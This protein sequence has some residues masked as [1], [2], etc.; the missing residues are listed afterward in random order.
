MNQ[1]GTLFVIA[2]TDSKRLPSKA[3]LKIKGKPLL[4]ILVD[5]IRTAKK[6]SKIV[7]CT[8]KKR[9]DNILVKF[10]KENNIDVYRGDD[11]DILKRI[12]FAAKKFQ[13]SNFILVEGDDVLCDPGLI[14]K[15]Y[16]ELIQGDKDFLYWSNLPF[17]VTPTGMKLKPL[18]KLIK[19][20]GDKKIETG[21]IKFVIDSKVF[22]TK[23][24][25]T[26]NKRLNRPDIRL[27]VDYKEDLKL[28]RR[29]LSHLP[30]N[31]KLDDI[32]KILEDN[33]NWLKINEVV[34]K[35]YLKNFNREKNYSE[36][37]CD[38]K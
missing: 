26:L 23:K 17:G 19:L 6:I 22:N 27:S 7:I 16:H 24:M 33:P 38:V 30:S 36:I 29:I 25:E 11:K 12:Y 31:F 35:K 10:L 1:L 14:D 34:K 5:R 18:E 37:Y 20:K 21:W 4:K 3:L 2:R 13:T 15:T 8:T 28:V 32:I 9:S